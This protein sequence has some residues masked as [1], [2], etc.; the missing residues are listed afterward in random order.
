MTPFEYFLKAY[1]GIRKNSKK[2][3]QVKFEKH[4]LEVQRLIF[5]DV[6][7]RKEGHPDWQNQQFIMAPSVYLNK[8]L[9]EDEVKDDYKEHTRPPR[10]TLNADNLCDNCRATWNSAVHQQECKK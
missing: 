1:P 9:W 4:S 10:E 7:K 8:A 3:C 2:Q 5:A 6:K